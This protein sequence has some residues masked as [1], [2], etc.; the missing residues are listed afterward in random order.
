[1]KKIKASPSVHQWPRK[2]V[3]SVETRKRDLVIRIA[4][5]TRDKSSPAYDV[6]CYI[7]GVYDFHESESFVSTW[8][9]RKGTTKDEAKGEAIAY[10]QA[11]IARLL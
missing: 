7:G 10:A 2:A 6:E 9:G 11:Q 4:D 1:M 8:D 3:T 5:W